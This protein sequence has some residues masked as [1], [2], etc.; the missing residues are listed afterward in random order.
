MPSKRVDTVEEVEERPVFGV[1]MGMNALAYVFLLG[2]VAAVVAWIVY[3]AKY[4][5]NFYR[6]VKDN[7][8]PGP[9]TVNTTTAPT[10]SVIPMDQATISFQA[11]V[12]SI[13]LYFAFRHHFHHHV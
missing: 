10:G 3:V 6:K 11:A 2:A 5:I 1:V 4:N 12:A 7:E 8:A 9:E 13:L